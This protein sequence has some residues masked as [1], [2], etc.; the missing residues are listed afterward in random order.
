VMNLV[1][2]GFGPTFVGFMSDYFKPTHPDNSLQLAFY[3]LAPFYAVAI[4]MFM[5]LASAL[6]REQQGERA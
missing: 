2:L 1:G 6:K 3:C 5:W 4:L